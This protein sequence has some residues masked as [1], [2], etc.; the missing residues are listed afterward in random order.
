MEGNVILVDRIAHVAIANGIVR[1]EFVA[2]TA[3]GQEKPSGT[4]LIPAIAAGSVIQGLVSAM[5]DLDR[6]ARDAAMAGTGSGIPATIPTGK[7]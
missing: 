5:Q 7:F 6:K 1:I 2:T 4:L 3:G